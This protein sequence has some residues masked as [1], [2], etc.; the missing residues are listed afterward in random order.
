[1]RI[2]VV[3]MVVLGLA[4][5]GA[6]ARP[7]ADPLDAAIVTTDLDAFF[8]IYDAAGGKP[9]A[10]DLAPY[11]ANGSP[12]VAGFIPNRIRSADHLARTIAARPQV[13][14][15]A[16]TCAGEIGSVQPRVRAAFLAMKQLHPAAAF[17]P[18]YILIGANNSGGTANDDGLMIGLEVVC[19]PGGPDP[20]PLGVRLGHLIAHEMVHS[21]Q[22][23]FEGESLLAYALNEGVA[24]FVSGLASGQPLNG[25]LDA[26]TAG[27]EAAIEQRFAADMHGTDYSAWLYNGVGTPESPGDLGYWVGARIAAAFYARQPDKR[28]AIA[29]LLAA[30]DARAL[31]AASGWSPAGAV[32]ADSPQRGAR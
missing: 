6:L 15:A 9:T 18:T 3:A 11:I 29:E 32:T 4:T 2:L 5:A 31:L 1:M 30:T 21:L 28:R 13:Y 26:W 25:H 8:R 24:E 22:K 7:A 23:G 20:A 16:R 10:T 27:K 12:G 14:A 17:K 19:R